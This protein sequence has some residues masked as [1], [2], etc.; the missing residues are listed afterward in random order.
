MITEP[1]ATQ[2]AEPRVSGSGEAPTPSFIELS[3]E[4]ILSWLSLSVLDE[5]DAAATEN[6]TLD[7]GEEDFWDQVARTEAELGSLGL[8][9]KDAVAQAIGLVGVGISL[10]DNGFDSGLLSMVS[11]ENGLAMTAKDPSRLPGASQLASVQAELVTR[12]QQAVAVWASLQGSALRA[13][14]NERG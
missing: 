7:H 12:A 5:H 14:C 10:G 6:G 8:V 3:D 1:S 9:G 11:A 4:E 13:A 2:I